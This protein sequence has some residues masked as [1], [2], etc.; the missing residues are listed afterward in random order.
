MNLA[1]FDFDGTIC[2]S[3]DLFVQRMNIAAPIYGFRKI[4]PQDIQNLRA[5][6][7]KDA[8]ESLGIG[9]LKLPFVVRYVKEGIEGQLLQLKPF[10]DFSNFF[11]DLK[12]QKSCSLGILTSNTQCNVQAYLKAHGIEGFSFV[13]SGNGLFSKAKYLNRIVSQFQRE[14]LDGRVFYIGDEVRDVLAAKE[15]GVKSIAVSWGYNNPEA[16]KKSRPDYLCED[17]KELQ[18]LLFDF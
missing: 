4:A 16:L 1:L 7:A 15:M 9:L 8:L 6:S 11:T 10:G 12:K 5:M 3:F 18:A 13:V 17:F 2:P 14:S